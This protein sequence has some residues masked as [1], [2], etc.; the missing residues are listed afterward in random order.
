LNA[1][2]DGEFAVALLLPH[3]L[4]TRSGVPGEARACSRR[5]RYEHAECSGQQH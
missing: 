1:A 5:C 3:R 4:R 2:S